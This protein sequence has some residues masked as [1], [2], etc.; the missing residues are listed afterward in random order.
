MKEKTDLIDWLY[1]NTKDGVIIL[2][3]N[4]IDKW[5][6][7]VMIIKAWEKYNIVVVTKNSPQLIKALDTS[8]SRH[9]TEAGFISFPIL[10]YTDIESINYYVD[11][12]EIDIILFDDAILSEGVLCTNQPCNKK[13]VIL[14]YLSDQFNIGLELD[15]QLIYLDKQMTNIIY[16]LFLS[17]LAEKPNS[18]IDGIISE[19]PKKQLVILNDDVAVKNL[20]FVLQSMRIQKQMP[21]EIEQLQEGNRDNLILIFNSVPNSVLDNISHIHFYFGAEPDIINEVISMCK[22]DEK[23]LTVNVYGSTQFDEDAFN[24][25]LHH[26]NQCDMA[27]TNYKKLYYD[28]NHGLF[29]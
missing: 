28:D 21:Y 17:R 18:L 26:I 15:L 16:R 14:S 8:K 6:I 11:N 4:S 7:L 13:F 27:K 25:F 9:W 5:E 1:N 19:W 3:Q 24:D 20:Y 12:S 23:V 29:V 2:H 22:K 10:D